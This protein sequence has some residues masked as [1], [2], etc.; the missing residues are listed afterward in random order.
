MGTGAVSRYKFDRSQETITVQNL[1]SGRCGRPGS[2][3]GRICLG[4]SILQKPCLTAQAGRH[5]EPIN[6]TVRVMG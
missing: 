4:S 1:F 3:F 6:Y 2:S 5:D